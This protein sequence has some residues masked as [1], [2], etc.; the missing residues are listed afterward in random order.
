MKGVKAPL[1]RA[2]IQ[3]KLWARLRSSAGSQME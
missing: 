3:R 2:L 1:Q